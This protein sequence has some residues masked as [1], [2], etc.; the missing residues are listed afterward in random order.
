MNLFRQLMEKPWLEEGSAVV[1]LHDGRTFPMPQAK[2]GLRVFLGVAMVLFSLMVAA[3]TERMVFSDWHSVPIPWL[4]WL[5]TGILISS[6]VAMHWALVSARWG[7]TESVGLGMAAGGVF[8]FAFLAGQLLA[9]RDL[10]EAGYYAS[11]DPANAFFYLLTAAHGIHL[12][13]GL[14]AWGKTVARIKRGEDAVR[15]RLSVE[16]CTI[17]WHFLLLIWLVLFAL[18][19]VT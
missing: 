16:L 12:I 8:A 14:V 11:L 7:R 10:A 6:S 4:L 2:L 9:W 5:N 17:Y 18:L 19:L 1:N 15:V 3:Y 13:G